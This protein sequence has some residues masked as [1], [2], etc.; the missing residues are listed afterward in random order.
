[1]RFYDA[2]IGNH[3][4]QDDMVE[5]R[6]VVIHASKPSSKVNFDAITSAVIANN[7]S[8]RVLVRYGPT[9]DRK[10]LFAWVCPFLANET[11][12]LMNK[13]PRDSLEVLGMSGGISNRGNITMD[14]KR[15][16][17]AM[18]RTTP[19]QTYDGEE[20]DEM[21]TVEDVEPVE[22]VRLEQGGGDE[23]REMALEQ[24]GY[25]DTEERM[26]EAS[27]EGEAVDAWE[28]AQQEE[29]E[30]VGDD[31]IPYLQDDSDAESEHGDKPD[32]DQ[33]YVPSGEDSDQEGHGGMGDGRRATRRNEK[34]MHMRGFEDEVSITAT[35]HFATCCVPQSPHFICIVS[36]FLRVWRTC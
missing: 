13:V 26:E 9:P 19:E 36:S 21:E 16:T 24:G 22:D 31:D 30:E 5:D 28:G 1:M 6:L 14:K 10:T 34:T 32:S 8:T 23:G 35:C 2:D 15:M 11:M 3:P 7:E 29:Q 25:G 12:E 17:A 4:L 20:T 33:E 27:E 18:L